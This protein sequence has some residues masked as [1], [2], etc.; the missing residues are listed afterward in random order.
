MNT[1]VIVAASRTPIGRAF[2]GTL[3]AE[4]PEDLVAASIREALRQANGLALEDIDDLM[5]GCGLPGGIQG[6]NLARTSA[7]LL[8]ADSLPAVTVTRY[9]TSSIQTTR[10]AYHAIAAGEGDTFLSVGVESTSSQSMASSDR[11]PGL[12]THHPAFYDA[13]V[14]SRRR[15]LAGSE[16]W[17]NPRRREQLP[18]PYLSMGQTAENLAQVYGIYRD[19]QDRFALRSQARAKAA[20]DAGFWSREITPYQ[21]ASGTIISAD[22][23]PRPG[24][25]AEGLAALVPVFRPD[26]TV[27]AGNSCPLNDGAA[28]LVIMGEKRAAER[29]LTP[30]ARVIATGVS[31]VSPEI[32]GLGPVES[33]RRALRHAGMSV[34]DIDLVEVNEAFAVQVLACA[35]ELRLDEDRL[36]ISGGA[37]AVGHPFG[38]SGA[39]LTVTMLNNLR[40]AD[41]ATGLITLCAAGGQG[42]SLIVERLS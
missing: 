38:M 37:I 15:A 27:T 1:A 34:G 14:T 39:R 9:C 30:L 24:T 23:S 40:S 26:G 28:A 22:D 33:S 7:V 18:D 11:I 42:M 21:T 16:R 8:G 29:G 6:N 41:A 35:R 2:K 13:E 19:E 12:D 31:A 5:L 17:E 25:T 10:M 3:A 32:M 36:N 20:Q 4:R